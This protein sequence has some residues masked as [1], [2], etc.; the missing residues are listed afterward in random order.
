MRLEVTIA[1]LGPARWR[2]RVDVPT[3]RLTGVADDCLGAEAEGATAPE[4]V[5]NASAKVIAL[6]RSNPELALSLLPIAGPELSL[7]LVASRYVDAPKIIHRVRREMRGAVIDTAKRISKG[8]STAKRAG[9]ATLR[10]VGKVG[11]VFKKLW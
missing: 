10:T 7:L 1:K 9:V 2:G 5:E 3:E 8:A 11:G 4:A 6:V